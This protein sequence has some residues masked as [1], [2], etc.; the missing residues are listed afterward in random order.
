MSRSSVTLAP[1]SVWVL[2]WSR[3]GGR[4]EELRHAC[5]ECWQVALDAVQQPLAQLHGGLDDLSRASDSAGLELGPHLVAERLVAKDDVTE[6][7]RVF[8]RLGR[9]L[10][11]GGRAGVGGV[12]DDHRPAA[13]PGGGQYVLLEP[14]V[15]DRGRVRERVTD[16]VPGPVVGIGQLAHD[17]Q[18]LLGRET[19]AVLSLLDEV[20]VHAVLA[21]RAVAGDVAGPAVDQVRAGDAGGPGDE[22]PADSHAG[23]AG[24]EID[25]ECV[26]GPGADAVR[27]D[28]EVIPAG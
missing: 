26:A 7:A 2:D 1:L 10:G 6:D 20:G 19:G 17:R 21:G 11:Q 15:V 22:G 24:L 12:P 5:H 3:S 23:A 8:Q 16:L 9:A 13:V 18:R 14:G 4:G 25:A 28:N 27:S